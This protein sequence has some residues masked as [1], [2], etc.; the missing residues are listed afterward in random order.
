M[1]LLFKYK[2]MMPSEFKALSKE[3]KVLLSAMLELEQEERINILK[4]TQGQISYI[5]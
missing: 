5:V 4:D 3:D 1:Y 2:N